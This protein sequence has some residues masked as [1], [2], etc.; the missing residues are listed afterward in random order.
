MSGSVFIAVPCYGGVIGW[1][2]CDTLMG[3]QKCF[4]QQGINHTVYFSPNT[5][6]V[7]KIRNLCANVVLYAKDA[8]GPIFNSLFFIDAD[9]SFNPEAALQM[10]RLNQGIVAL[11]FTRKLIDWGNVAKAAKAGFPNEALPQF[12]GT[13]IFENDG[14]PF[15]LTEPTKA[16]VGCGAMLIQR[17]VLQALADKHPEWS[18]RPLEHEKEYR[19]A[20][21]PDTAIDFFQAR[22]DS[23]TRTYISEDLFF[24]KEARKLGLETHVLPWFHTVH[25]G[26]FDYHLNF[27]AMA[28]VSKSKEVA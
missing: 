20:S 12:G 17:S 4:S 19:D 7:M 9:C 3:I 8:N 26:Q 1:R 14:K 21:M 2:T 6:L 24:V 10:V 5:S 15:E 25:T 23:E 22:I 27:H 16:M 18:Y 28:Q 13:P 11:P